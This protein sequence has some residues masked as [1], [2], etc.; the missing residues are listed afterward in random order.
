MINIEIK[1]IGSLER[2]GNRIKGKRK[3]KRK[4]RGVGWEYVNV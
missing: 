1:R 3:R 2:V 4:K